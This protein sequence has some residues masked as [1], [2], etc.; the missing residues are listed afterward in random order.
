ME[1]EIIDELGDISKWSEVRVHLWFKENG[2]HVSEVS[3]LAYRITYSY[4]TF[5]VE[6]LY[7]KLI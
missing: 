6:W 5:C 2:Y 1:N 4:V 3:S 7:Q